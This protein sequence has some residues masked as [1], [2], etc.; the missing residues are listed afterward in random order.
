[1]LIKKRFYHL[2]SSIS[3]DLHGFSTYRFNSL[4]LEVV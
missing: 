1:M 2:N 3:T 4:A